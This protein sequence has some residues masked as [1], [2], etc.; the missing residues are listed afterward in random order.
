MKRLPSISTLALVLLVVACA[1]RAEAQTDTR[2][3]GRR[4][5][6]RP[7]AQTNPAELFAATPLTDFR[8]GETYLGL[9]GGLYG[10]GSNIPSRVHHEAG[11]R[12]AASVRPI[13][14]SIVLMSIGMSNA[15]HEWEA[16]LRMVGRRQGSAWTRGSIRMINGAFGGA[17]ADVWD[18]RDARA[19]D[20]LRDRELAP[21]GVTEADVQVVWLKLTHQGAR[22]SL[23]DPQ[24]DMFELAERCGRVITALESRYPNLRQVF[25][26]SRSYGGYRGRGGKAEPFAYEGGFAMRACILAREGKTD[27]WVGWGP[28][29]W[30]KGPTPRA[31]GFAWQ[32]QDF[33]ADALHPSDSGEAKVAE[34]IAK[35]FQTSAYTS[36][37]R[38]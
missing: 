35:F 33:T 26:S 31:D 37:Y 10:G 4:G 25:L 18:G 32:R 8:S 29:L 23:P 16:F 9:E 12:A 17:S 36:W 13:N 14:G 22:R 24:A 20:R 27:P 28:Y 34:L 2:A 5:Q 15:H 19:Y 30:A 21:Q 6:D 38:Q 1:A 11:L 3:G 7:R